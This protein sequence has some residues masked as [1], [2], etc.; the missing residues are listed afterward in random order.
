MTD[1]RPIFNTPE[2]KPSAGATKLAVVLHAYKSNAEGMKHVAEAAK[3]ALGDDV[4]VYCP[5]LPHSN[6]C[7]MTGAERIVLGLVASLNKIW[8]DKQKL[9]PGGYKEVVLIGH[10]LGGALA[11]RL[12]LAGSLNP[13]DYADGFSARDELLE[14]VIELQGGAHPGAE[15]TK[16]L[17]CAWAPRVTRVLLLATWD[18]GWS[19]SPRTSWWASAGLNFLGLVGRLIELFEPWGS[20]GWTPARTMLDMRQGARFIVQTRLLWMAYRRWHNKKIQEKYD[21]RHPDAPLG[22]PATQ[23]SETGEPLTANPLVVQIIAS[24]DD[25]VSPQDQI[26]IDAEGVLAWLPDDGSTGKKNY[27][28]LEMSGADHKGVVELASDPERKVL[29]IAGLTKTPDEFAAASENDLLGK[30]LRNPVDFFDAPPAVDEDANDVVFVVHGIRDDGNWTHRIAA[31]IKREWA[32]AEASEGGVKGAARVDFYPTWTNSYGFF[33]MLPFILPWIRKSKVEWF[34]DKYVSVKAAYPTANFHYVGHSNGTYICATALHDYPAARFRGVYFAGSVVHPRFPWARIV[35]ERRI[36]RFHN[37][38]GGEDWVV[39]LLPKSLEYFTDLG[40]AGFDGFEEKPL[41]GGKVSWPKD[42]QHFTQSAGYALGGHGGAITEPHWG[43]IAKF[44]VRGAKP[45]AAAEPPALFARS[46]NQL[47]KIFGALRIGAP[48]GFALAGLF[49]LLVVS[50]PDHDWWGAPVLGWSICIVAVILYAGQFALAFCFGRKPWPTR[51]AY[52][53]VIALVILLLPSFPPL[54]GEAAR[55]YGG[56]WAAAVALFAVAQFFSSR[57]Y[58]GLLAGWRSG[59][60]ADLPPSEKLAKTLAQLRQ[61][62]PMGWAKTGLTYLFLIIAVAYWFTFADGL[63]STFSKLAA[64]G[65]GL[66]WAVALFF[67]VAGL[68]RFILLRV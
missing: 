6:P 50:A 34:M 20:R 32:S 60:Y 3:Q 55:L 13:P 68:I 42:N 45:F 12:F 10:S 44:I 35:R 36:E 47:Y 31:A 4:D 24:Q 30:A 63:I 2:F 49:M 46:Q 56:W 26:D 19:V 38:R 7:D 57:D 53:L 11:R 1:A 41:T 62:A 61:H 65:A 37:A 29:V 39:A 14:A 23:R 27:F 18:K 17:P 40:G 54:V 33:P 67:L 59:E 51:T 8:S 21:L 25:F 28:L 5:T 43:E 48:L 52:P 66:G 9:T 15:R 16:L 58:S 22:D 64:G